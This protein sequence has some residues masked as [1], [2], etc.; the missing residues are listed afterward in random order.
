MSILNQKIKTAF[1]KWR[2]SGSLSVAY[3]LLAEALLI[4]FV[5][6]AGL[7]TIETIL[8]TFISV[9]LNLTAFLALLLIGSFLLATLGRFLNIDFPSGLR[10]RNPFLWIGIVWTIGILAV[11]LY[12]FP[13]FLIPILILTFL[14][15]GYLFSR[16]F[17]GEK[18]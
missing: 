7:F 17:F 18:E 1:E 11:S 15:I 9:R 8:P 16:I 14:G 3:A 12:K 2:V 5:T 6:F 13:L 4:G 10:W